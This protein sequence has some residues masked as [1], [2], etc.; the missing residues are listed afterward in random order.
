MR[1]ETYQNTNTKAGSVTLTKYSI[2]PFYGGVLFVVFFSR[3]MN[4]WIPVWMFE[5]FIERT[6]FALFC[7]L[8]TS[9]NES[10]SWTRMW[11]RS[12]PQCWAS[13]ARQMTLIHRRKT[14]EQV[15]L[16]KP[17]P[18]QFWSHRSIQELFN[19]VAVD[20]RKIH[21]LWEWKQGKGMPVLED[22][23]FSQRRAT[24]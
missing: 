9:Q 10:V 8:W 16:G 5:L 23:V 4:A 2:F 1:T 3:S 24:I 19:D 11:F 6:I 20:R 14:Q 22:S 12:H 15:G 18:M 21:I 13:G 7:H 17:T